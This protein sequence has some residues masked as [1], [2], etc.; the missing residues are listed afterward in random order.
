M[1]SDPLLLL[2]PSAD[3]HI[4]ELESQILQDVQS[5][6]EDIRLV[7]FSKVHCWSSTMT[8]L[9][10]YSF[11]ENFFSMTTTVTTSGIFGVAAVDANDE[12]AGYYVGRSVPPFSD[13]TVGFGKKKVANLAQICVG[14]NYQQRGIAQC[15][16][17]FMLD[18]KHPDFNPD[19]YDEIFVQDT[20]VFNSPSWL[21]SDRVGFR[22]FPTHDIIRRLGLSG[23]LHIVLMCQ[24]ALPGQFLKRLVKSDEEAEE[25]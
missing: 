7:P 25:A 12:V 24:H 22:Y 11:P 23:Y 8:T 4:H 20:D 3:D 10:E 13:G 14:S 15:M 6:D 18:G 19:D 1:S 5:D 9:R 21:F 17:R 2:N 16:G